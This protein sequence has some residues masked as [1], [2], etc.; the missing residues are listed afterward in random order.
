M[1]I[2]NGYEA[3]SLINKNIKNQDND[4][5]TTLLYALTSDCSY[6][7]AFLIDQHPFYRKFDK[8]D[9]NNE[10]QTIII[11]IKKKNMIKKDS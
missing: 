3:C 5:S 2:M 8:L 10:V 1:P 7:T 4:V 9:D 6:E 11:D